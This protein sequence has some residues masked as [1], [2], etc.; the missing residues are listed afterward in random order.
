MAKKPIGFMVMYDDEQ[1]VQAHYGAD[2]ECAGAIEYSANAPL[3]FADRAAARKAITISERNAR[4][5]EAQGLPENS[6]F[7]TGKKFIRVVPV[8]AAG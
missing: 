2:A 6:D 4:L 1:G 7:T 8:Y 5:R 3:L